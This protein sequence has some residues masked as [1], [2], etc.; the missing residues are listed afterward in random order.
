MLFNALVMPGAGHCRI[1]YKRRGCIIM[2]AIFVL[3]TIPLVALIVVFHDTIKAIDPNNPVI[4]T[5]LAG[6]S[7]AWRQLK[8][9]ILWCVGGI[10]AGW[11]ASLLDLFW[12]KSRKLSS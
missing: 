5:S 4:E 2:A 7:A 9:V 11:V 12:L 10:F 8:P 3:M 1:G 6:L